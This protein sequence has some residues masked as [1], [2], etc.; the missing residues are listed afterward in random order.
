MMASS[1]NPI[2]ASLNNPFVLQ[3]AAVVEMVRDARETR[4]RDRFSC[5]FEEWQLLLKLASE[6]GWQ[7]H[8]TTYELPPSSKVEDPA[9]HNY[10]PGEPSDR[11]RVDAQDS[12]E[13]A[14]ALSEA[15]GS[16]R[17][18]AMVAESQNA[19]VSTLISEF[20]EYAYGGAFMFA[21]KDDSSAER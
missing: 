4:G 12:N 7:P 13:L 10:E 5:T 16:P 17:L 15:Q 21:R 6:F 1:E 19:S 3:D 9:R 18:A 8:D 2:A 20:I 11:K 14:R